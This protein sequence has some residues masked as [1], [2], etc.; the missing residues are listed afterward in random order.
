V[1]SLRSNELMDLQA[2]MAAAMQRIAELE[3]A[4]QRNC[5]T[6]GSRPAGNDDTRA[7]IR[8]NKF[9]RQHRV[10]PHNSARSPNADD[11]LYNSGSSNGDTVKQ[12]TRQVCRIWHWG[13]TVCLP[14][15]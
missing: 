14:Q 15:M 10:S 9:R 11:S 8:D 2:R 7:V 12:R 5:G 13:G 6:A 4:V 1:S 3:T